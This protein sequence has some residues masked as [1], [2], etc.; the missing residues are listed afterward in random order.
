MPSIA[1]RVSTSTRSLPSRI[2]AIDL[3]SLVLFRV[4]L[5]ALLLIDLCR[6]LPQLTAFYSDAGVLPRGQQ[7]HGDVL[8]RISLHA[9]NGQTLF[10]L[11]LVAVA[12]LAALALFVGW[13][14]RMAAIVSFVLYASL[15]NRA[16]VIV[17]GGEQFLALLLFW[18]CFLPL[19]TR[20]SVDAALAP[21]TS[22]PPPVNPHL[23]WASAALLLQ[24]GIACLWVTA[25]APAANP[26][27]A[28]LSRQ[29]YTAPA[30]LWLQGHSVLLHWTQ[31]LVTLIGLLAPLLLFTP[32]ARWP[33]RTLAIIALALLQL[34]AL[35]CFDLDLTPWVGLVALT[36]FIGA[37]FW[38]RMDSR[39]VAQ[40]PIRLFYDQRRSCSLRLQQLLR[41]FLILPSAQLLAA[42]SQPRTA[43]LL[44]AN[45]SW[46]VID[47][48]DRA[49]LRWD[50]LV[51]LMRRS[52]LF[53][54][55]GWLLSKLPLSAIGDKAY[56]LLH[57]FDGG[58][59][60]TTAASPAP[61][62]AAQTGQAA[63][64]FAA[65]C[66][67]LAV[68]WNLSLAGLLPRAIQHVLAPPLRLLRLDQPWHHYL[69]QGAEGRGWFVIP[70]RLADDRQVD[71]LRMGQTLDFKTPAVLARRQGN[72]FWH[73]YLDALWR[74][75]DTHDRARY[76]DYLCRRWN[77][78]AAPVRKLQSLRIVYL[79]ERGAPNGSD[80]VE[81]HVLWRQSCGATPNAV[82]GDG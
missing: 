50:A 40:T 61:I 77:A 21:G 80:N 11:A 67:L 56:R 76:A 34:G 75:Q 4:T 29:T 53:G 41:E 49:Y 2:F 46:I 79:L 27:A 82:A 17:G 81:Q 54:P 30:G 26:L 44:Q 19:S 47:H 24:I 12:L 42:Q 23:S 69:P 65:L 68:L 66:L 13:R 28:I 58:A 8:W 32:L 38:A 45:D 48:D 52:P 10:E 55:A 57:R 62:Q 36:P 25:L 20:W 78:D 31:W 43:T 72:S 64:R 51:M 70:G 14:T 6:H 39:A 3:R 63:Q 37:G 1:A 22:A 71:L 73:R 18:A 74:R 35:I 15:L 7:P 16:P 59:A 9:A 60:S 33:L 5:A